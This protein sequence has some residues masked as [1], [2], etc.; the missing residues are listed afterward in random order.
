MA[1][2]KKHINIALGYFLI[3]ALLGL[4]LR[5]FTVI[6]IA[7]NYKYVI[8]THSHIALLG[9]VYTALTTLIYKIYLTKKEIYK[10][11]KIIFWSTQVTIIGMLVT[12]PFMGYALYS[13]IFSTLFLLASYWFTWFFITHT[14]KEQKGTFSYKCIRIALYYMI[15]SS[16]GPWALGA[17]M[18]TLGNTSIWYKNAIYF[19]LHFQYNGWYIMALLGIFF[20][21]LEQK[22]I[23]VSKPKPNILYTT[24]QTGILLSFF[25]SVLWTEPHFVFYILGGVGA[26]F[27]IV[28]YYI[29]IKIIIDCRP[30]LYNHFSTTERALFILVTSLL[31]LKIG[32]QAISSIPYF[33]ELAYGIIDFVIGYLHLT[34]LGVVSLCLFAFLS[35]LKLLKLSKISMALFVI[36]F[37][38][39][40]IL[41]IYKGIV[42]WLELSLFPNYFFSLACISSLM[43]IGIIY[44]LVYQ[45]KS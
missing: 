10:T 44:L 40:E 29:L 33:S 23:S 21:I 19:Y 2:L 15:L 26:L 3:I 25:L 43:A 34:F 24:L 42:I 6:P 14:S 11:Y 35:H 36:G 7:A 45:L 38:G 17:I 5:L 32:L 37:L 13:I 41:I 18:N 20:F 8:H 28:A 12:F 9:W 39:S 27:Q 30:Q 16:I 31:G 1:Y 22:K 4:L